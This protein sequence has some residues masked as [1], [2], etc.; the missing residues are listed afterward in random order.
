MS[1]CVIACLFGKKYKSVYPS[2][3]NYD[4]YLFT[5]NPELKDIIENAGWKYIFIDFPLSDDEAISSFQSNYIRYLQ[6]LKIES[7]NLFMQYDKI[8]YIDHKLELKD[9]HVDFLIKKMVDKKIMVRKHPENLK[10]IWEELG[11]AVIQERYLRFIPQTIDYIMGKIE[12]GYSERP[13][14]ILTSLIF[15]SHL[16]KS[17][18]EFVDEVYND[19]EKT[20]TSECIIIWAMVEQKYKGLINVLKWSELEIKSKDPEEEY[21]EKDS[22]VYLGGKLQNKLNNINLFVNKYKNQNSGIQNDFEYIEQNMESVIYYKDELENKTVIMEN[23]LKKERNLKGEIQNQ[24]EHRNQ[25]I[26]IV[27]LLEKDLKKKTLLTGQLILA[28]RNLNAVINNISSSIIWNAAFKFSVFNRKLFPLN[29]KR[30]F[31]IKKLLIFI[32]N[33]FNSFYKSH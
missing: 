15:Y 18:M 10:N 32:K 1:I 4:A 9:S 27:S 14:I 13:V 28:E 29:S 23:L 33:P 2:V 22:M 25:L 24:Y 7:F 31:L 5:N 30:R 26:E 11:N 12:E 16:D 21:I 19:L 17:V 8:L 6:F 20:G 3:K